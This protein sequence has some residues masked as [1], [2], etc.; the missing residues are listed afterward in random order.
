MQA[1]VAA[2]GFLLSSLL[3]CGSICAQE[4]GPEKDSSPSETQIEPPAS[5]VPPR[6]LRITKPKYPQS[7]FIKRIEGTVVVEILID[8]KGRVA[9]SR[10]VQSV[11]ELDAAALDCV[12]KWRFKPA[13]KAGKAVAAMAQAPIMF[14]LYSKGDPPKH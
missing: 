9:R 11:P 1:G 4:P 13:F 3:I 12:R 6:P 8:A 2:P 14:R 5:D 7:A 10:I